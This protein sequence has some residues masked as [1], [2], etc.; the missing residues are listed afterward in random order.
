VFGN[1]KTPAFFMN[2]IEENLKSYKHNGYVHSAGT[3]AAR[4]AVAQRFSSAG[5]ELTENDVVI[6]CGCSGALD[7]AITALCNAGETLLVPRPGFALYETLAQSKGIA[8]AYYDLNSEKGWEVDLDSLDTAI[9]DCD[10]PAAI[11]VNNPSNPCGSVYSAE[12]LKA[13]IEIAAKHCTP[14]IA[15][16]I[17]RN[18]VFSTAKFVPM[19]GLSEDVPVLSVGGIAKE[20]LVPGWRVGWVLVHDKKG[21]F[22]KVRDGLFRL[23]QLVLGSCSL[24]QSALPELLTPSTDENKKALADFTQATLAQLED[25]AKFTTERLKDVVG[26]N[27][28]VP[29]GAMYVM[30]GIDASKFKDIDGDIAFTQM[31][32]EEEHVFMLPGTCFGMAKFARIVFSAPKDKLAEAYDRIEKFCKAHAV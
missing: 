24:I 17:Y 4:K 5:A 32:L 19:A 13:V 27:V 3:I 28:I 22:S 7:L 26:I 10:A 8:V 11:L 2:A 30:I 1:F 9:K 15:D 18:I 21:R 6:G 20:F 14:I 31:L 23:S 16:E 29:D 12:H 25:N